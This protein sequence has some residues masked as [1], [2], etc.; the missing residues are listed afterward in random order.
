M[1]RTHR[2]LLLALGLVIPAARSDAQSVDTTLWVTDG[3]VHST[4]RV[5]NTIYLAGQFTRVGPA[6][7]P[8]FPV[9][10]GAGA[11]SGAY[12]KLVGEVFAEVGDGL[13]GRFV[14]G[15]FVSAGGIA[16]ANLVHVLADGTV[17][18]WDPG[19]DG[20]VLTLALSGGVLYVGGEFQNIAGQ[21]RSHVAA[22]D[23]ETGA[24]LPWNPGADGTVRTLAR[25]GSV[26]YAGGDFANAG[27]QPRPYLAA[28]DAASGSAT[29]WIPNADGPVWHVVPSGVRVLACGD[30]DHI[31]GGLR[32]HAAALDSTSALAD[33]WDPNANRLVITLA[34][35][36]STIYLGGAFST[37]NGQ[38]RENLAAVDATSGAP[39]AWNPGATGHVW[40]I[41]VIGTTVYFSGDFSSVA[42]TP[43][44]ALAAVDALTGVPT[45]WNPGT[46]PTARTLTPIEGRMFVGAEFGSAGVVLRRNLAALDA[47]TG[48]AL[49]WDPDA[50]GGIFAMVKLGST[51]YVGGG[52]G[53]LGGQG[54]NGLAAIDMA[55]GAVKP[56]NPNVAGAVFALAARDNTVY[57][58]G[59]FRNVGGQLRQNLVALDATT[60]AVT[61]WNPA[62]DST[63][64]TIALGT[65]SLVGARNPWGLSGE[66]AQ[67]FDPTR[68]VYV[69]GDFH[70]VGGQPRTAVAAVDDSLG[71]ATAWNPAPG[72]AT[73]TV[74]TVRVDGSGNSVF[75]GGAFATIQGQPRS[76]LAYLSIFN[77][78]QL[79]AWH[80]DPDGMVTAMAE[81]GD[82]F[83]V[84]GAFSTI[85][86][87]SRNGLAALALNANYVTE[88]NPLPVRSVLPTTSIEVEPEAVY[89]GGY[90]QGIANHPQSRVA[91][92]SKFSFIDVPEAPLVSRFRLASSPNPARGRVAL[93]FALPRAGVVR[94]ALYDVAGR[95]VATP[96]DHGA[97]PAGPGSLVFGTDDLAPGLYFAELA[98]GTEMESIK[99]I[100][101]R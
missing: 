26:V 93:T 54:R 48:A 2:V 15:S 5:G 22:L 75:I 97:L 100:V 101:T 82:A 67:A 74:R 43:R 58:G 78:G 99:L 88:W 40:D 23:P 89:V 71:L 68:I 53:C 14:G 51:M 13:G 90:F 20:T 98:L 24:V 61:S 17:D 62:A 65:P 1:N 80:P 83:Y 28:I 76:N 95:R 33:A 37:V 92:L 59:A 46:M 69:G 50:C 87:K 18:G 10:L 6:I 49:P 12:P 73:A 35:S 29:G 16:R 11:V 96:I 8:S 30:F 81:D 44:Q 57:A 25:N 32:H 77:A 9:D 70:H 34:Q 21:P 38:P 55:T 42:N 94:L 3:P 36:G 63:V 72:P 84:G 60:G 66:S 4:I 41:E 31:G 86:G 45:A 27:G 64:K 56:W 91:A 47:T 52:F 39:S 7:G 85:G 79:G 19:T